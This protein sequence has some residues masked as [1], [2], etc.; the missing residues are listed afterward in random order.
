MPWLVS[1]PK[2]RKMLN[3]RKAK[4][5]KRITHI[6]HEERKGEEEEEEEEGVEGESKE[7]V[8]EVAK[9][10]SIQYK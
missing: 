8:G 2:K 10:G 7:G 9:E 4:T 1:F 3:P 5:T 6:F